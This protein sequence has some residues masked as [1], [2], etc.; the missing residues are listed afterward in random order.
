MFFDHES[1]KLELKEK[2]LVG[3]MKM[4]DAKLE[5]Q[6]NITSYFSW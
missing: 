6:W 1:L 3:S 4:F 2:R 5:D